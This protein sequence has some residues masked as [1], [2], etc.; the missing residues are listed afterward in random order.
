MR[1]ATSQVAVL[2]GPRNIAAEIGNKDNVKQFE[3]TKANLHESVSKTIMVYQ[4]SLVQRIL[5]S[6]V[7]KVL[8]INFVVFSAYLIAMDGVV[9]KQT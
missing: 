4:T 9:W 6:G 7:C 8:L 1:S 3:S 5:V 2:R